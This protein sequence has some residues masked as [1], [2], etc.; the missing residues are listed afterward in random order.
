V[1]VNHTFAKL[2]K[3]KASVVKAILDKAGPRY[4]M[5]DPAT[6]AQQAGIAA[7]GDWDKLKKLQDKLDG[8]RK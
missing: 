4:Q 8:G 2:S 5:H 3:T 6:W 1:E 7:K